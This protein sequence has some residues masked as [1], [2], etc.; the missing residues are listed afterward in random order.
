MEGSS[1]SFIGA[2]NL[3]TTVAPPDAAARS[4]V[5]PATAME[6]EGAR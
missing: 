4:L 2:R 6:R 1:N 5:N 3:P